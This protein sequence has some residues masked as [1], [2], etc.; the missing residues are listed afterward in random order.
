MK[1]VCDVKRGIYATRPQDRERALP[2]SV[3]LWLAGA[4]FSSS[5]VWMGFFLLTSPVE[6]SNVRVSLGDLI[7]NARP[8]AMMNVEVTPE[9]KIL[10]VHDSGMN[11]AQKMAQRQETKRISR[12]S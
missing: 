9:R 6:N 11:R 1:R 4:A 5:L 3:Q 12:S 8:C 2:T 7:S 10:A